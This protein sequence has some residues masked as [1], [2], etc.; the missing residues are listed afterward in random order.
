MSQEQDA[1]AGAEAKLVHIASDRIARS[2][3]EWG[4]SLL[5]D[6]THSMIFD[7]SKIKAA[8]PAF[9]ATI[10]YSQGARETLAWF[11]ADLTRRVTD[12]AFDALL[13]RL[14]DA[15]NRLPA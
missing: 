3:P 12:P 4:V 11:D 10:P 15:E 7:N 13:D 2:D 1:A 9:R 5:G 8:V 14:I 6:K